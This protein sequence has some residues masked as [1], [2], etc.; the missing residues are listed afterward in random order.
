MLKKFKKAIGI[1]QGLL[2]AVLVL[3]VL[4][5]I[6]TAFN[7]IK[8]FQLF[9][10]M[11]GSMEPK[12]KVGSV[13]FVRKV[14]PEVLK[15]GEVITYSSS[16]NPEMSITH[17]LVEIEEKE[18]KT[19]FKTRGDA[20]NNEDM[21][22]VSPS[23][24]K[25]KVIFSLPF[26]G[27]LSV[28]I[29]KPL[30]FG[31]LV[32]LPAL[33]IIISEILSIK[34]AIEKEVEKKYEEK[35]KFKEKKVTA[36][37]LIF[38]LLGISLLRI[39]PADAYFSDVMIIPDNTFSMANDWVTPSPSPT[40]TATP[41]PAEVVINEV[42]YDV[43]TRV[44]GG[45][46]EKEGDNE[47]VELYNPTDLAINVSGWKICDNTDCDVIPTSDPIS[48]KGF[49][50]IT[51]EGTTWNYWSSIP[52]GAIKIVLNNNIGSGLNDAGDQLVLKNSAGVEID[53]VAW[54][55]G[56]GDVHLEWDITANAG[57]SI[58]RIEKGVD[59][60]SVDDWHV[61]DEPN[62]GTNPHPPEE[63]EENKEE[64]LD[65]E[66]P[67]L[68]QNTMELSPTPTPTVE[69]TP[70]PEQTPTPTPSTT[71]TPSPG[72]EPTQA[73]LPEPS[74]SPTP[75][76]IPSQEPSPSPEPS[77][78]PSPEPNPPACELV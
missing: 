14:K 32:I 13:V 64:I 52:D 27:Y 34:K 45:V 11:S 57:Q 46:V 39:K 6:F 7:P 25:G 61:L 9:R 48:S 38:F 77:P 8:S 20:N 19:V 54:E 15:K 65:L 59:T 17:R 68:G 16:E 40:P 74:V 55:G 72:P 62:P 69:P 30:G 3:A 2:T 41:T 47:W 67:E 58:A 36:S 63:P 51:A 50:V 31:L 24:I 21:A 28:W 60:D 22:E 18:G 43:G 29:K 26:L 49:A 33:L 71:P 37:L 53:F 70:V 23:Q 44:F 10:V 35:E 66:E 5:L 56:H 4:L 42:Y 76:P 73:P 75:T 78:T 1:I 12:I